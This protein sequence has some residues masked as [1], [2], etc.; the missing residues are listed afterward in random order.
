MWSGGLTYN[1]LAE[2]RSKYTILYYAILYYVILYYFM[3]YY[4]LL[5]LYKKK[6]INDLLRILAHDVYI[7][8]CL[9]VGLKH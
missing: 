4:I 3:L 6:I 1:L 5:G 7:C 9:C 8:L 2:V